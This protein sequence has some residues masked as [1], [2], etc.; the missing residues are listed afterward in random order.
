MK[1]VFAAAQLTHAPARFLSLG[2]IVDYPDNPDRARKLLEGARRAESKIYAARTY[3]MEVLE[4]C[5][6]QEYLQFLESAFA[7][8]KQIEGA[9]PE[10][11]PS[12]RPLVTPTRAP[13][14]ILG[15]AGLYMMDFSCPITEAT[16][17]AARASAFTALTAAD[18]VLKGDRVVYALCRPPGHHAYAD[19]AAGFCYLNN[20]ALAAEQLR[21]AHDRVAILDIDCH[22]GNGTQSIFYERSDVLTI[23]IH[24]NPLNFY[25]FYWGYPREK[26]AGEGIGY[27]HNMPLAVGAGDGPWLSNLAEACDKIREY[28]PGAMVVSVGFDA[29]EADPL[30]G[31][32][33]TTGGF[34]RMAAMI[35]G[36][37]I[38]A[39]LVQ[40]GGYGNDLLPDSLAAFLTGFERVP[41]AAAPEAE[42]A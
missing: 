2:N 12:L 4:R 11:M 29:H 40:E 37:G 16:W 10:L 15:R 30:K 32:T 18:L 33:V 25:P 6:A 39:V 13:R 14:H 34:S 36:L 3:D 21:T 35:A 20:A 24:A 23:S 9:G 17:K 5:H 22:H 42:T 27:N 28:E 19:L 31:G 41:A 26:G 7:E 8:W 1:A 38:P